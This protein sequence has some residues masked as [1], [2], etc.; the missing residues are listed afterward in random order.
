MATDPSVMHSVSLLF[1]YLMYGLGSVAAVSVI[2]L[3]VWAKVKLLQ[4][5]I[6]NAGKT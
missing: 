6:A 2:G 1:Q 4:G 3:A 5:I